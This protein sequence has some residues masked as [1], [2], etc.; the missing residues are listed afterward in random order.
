MIPLSGQRLTKI[1]KSSAT[2]RIIALLLLFDDGFASLE[3]MRISPNKTHDNS[4][5]SPPLFC[6]TV[7]QNCTTD[8]GS[9]G[10]C[11][12]TLDSNFVRTEREAWPRKQ[13][14]RSQGRILSP[15][16]EL[17]SVSSF[18]CM[19]TTVCVLVTRKRSHLQMTL[20]TREPRYWKA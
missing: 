15:T 20:K 11:M 19:E 6:Q 18:D 13:P 4:L 7:M 14:W 2:C 10:D 16:I 17:V 8:L 1:D 5:M 3:Q 12:D 9:T